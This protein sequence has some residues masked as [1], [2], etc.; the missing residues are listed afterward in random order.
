MNDRD[1]W[2]KIVIVGTLV[3]LAFASIH[4][5]DEKLKYGIDLYGGYSLLYEIDDTGVA[6][7][8]KRELSEKVM[9]VLR[10]RVDPKGVYNLVWRPVG[11]NRLEIQMPR[12][13][14]DVRKARL[15]YDH[16]Q[17][18]IQGT[19]LRRSDVLRALARSG[20]ERST[21]FDELIRGIEARKP[22]LNT[23]VKAYDDW[24]TMKAQYDERAKLAAKDN[25]SKDQIDDAM[26]QTGAERLKAI[27]ALIRGLPQRRVILDEAAKAW[28]AWNAA[29]PA[30]QAASPTTQAALEAAAK[31]TAYLEA[32][33]KVLALNADPAKFAEGAT[34]DKVVKLEEEF[35]AA[36]AALL[37]TNIDIG[38]LQVIL[39]TKPGTT[40]RKESLDSFNKDFS[41]VSRLVE[42]LLKANDELGKRRHGGEGRLEDPADLQR[43]LKGAGVLEFR[44]LAEGRQASPEKFEPYVEA[45]K[46]AGPRRSPGE[47]QYQWFEVEDP[48]DFLNIKD[49][50]KLATDFER[51][52][53]GMQ[54]IVERFGDKYYVLT[55]IGDAY[56]LT[57]RQ[58]E[59]DWSLKAA[60]FQ[61][62]Q[63]G[64]P[65]I[66]FE[67]DDVGGEH[68]AQLTRLNKGRQ[69]AIFLDDQAVSH[70]TIQSVIRNSGEITGTFTPQ[71]VQ[72]MVKK[73]DAGSLPRKLKDP[74]ISVKAIGPSLGE[75]NRTAGLRA[76]EY[77]SIAVVLFMCGFYL[78]AGSISI[79]ACAINILFT[80]SAMA[81]MGAT[82][83]LPGIA[84]LVLSIG[85]A[86][87]SNVLINERIREELARGTAM[88][89][90]IKHGYERAFS[91]ILDS[92]VTAIL[93]SLILYF[94]GSEE[95]KGFGLTLCIA[96][97]IN[98]FTAYFI[99][100]MFFDMMVAPSVPSEIIRKPIIASLVIIAIGAFLYGAGYY[101]NGPA[102]RDTSVL[103]AFGRAIMY[104]GPSTLGLL[105]LMY[106]GR[107]VHQM[108]QT[109][110]KPRLPMMHVIG[111][112]HID[113][114]GM[115]PFFFTASAILTIAGL[116]AF[117]SLG[118]KEIY[119][120]EFLGG[121][122][123]QI[124]LKQPGLL[125]QAGV[126]DRLKKS[127][128]KLDA[129]AA[130]SEKATLTSSAAATFNLS[131]PGVPAVR[132]E[133]V[134]KEVLGRKLS[135]MSPITYSDPASESM[136]IRTRTDANVTLDEMQRSLKEFAA[137]FR[138]AAEFIG[139]AQVQAIASAENPEE[140]DKSFEIITLETNKD[141]VVASIMENL[142][143]ELNIQRALSFNMMDNQALGAVS[144]F[145]LRS[146]NLKE[147][148]LPIPEAQANE[149]DLTGWKGSAA[150][151]LDK[152]DPPQKLD[153]LKDR[154]RAMR[155][156]PGFESHGWRESTVFGLQAVPG[157]DL[158][159][160]VMVVVADENY[161]IA[162]EQGGLS[163][164]WV[165]ELAEPEV[166][167][168]QSALQRQT[169]LSQI[170]QFDKQVSGEAQTNAFIA[171]G[172]SWLAII[173]YLWFRFGNI[174]W[175]LA[176]VVALIHDVIVAI[177][178]IGLA[179]YLADTAI[180]HALKLEK[181]RVDLGLVAAILTI[182]GYSVSDTIIIFDRIR[183]NR[184]RGGELTPEKVNTAISQTLARTF[185]TS[186]TTMST[187]V[188]MYWV[189]GP[190]IHGFNFAMM[191]GILTGTY[192]SFA[193]ASQLLVK[194][195]LIKAVATA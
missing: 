77:G 176:A 81:I 139:R 133:P 168:V 75:A 95:I 48:A 76:A 182:I 100:K 5:T 11:Y 167:L 63:F 23:T 150:M 64:R 49:R 130:A 89:M 16:L 65:A 166:Q 120:I 149:I 144:Y 22:L 121:T 151:I 135:E 164:T 138:R 82:L 26:K 55:H 31:E 107:M 30:A 157:S 124:D 165:S 178:C 173:I 45:L 186:F 94:L 86:V 61:R 70:A 110:D 28:D 83:T 53:P 126:Q 79:F 68:F 172:L 69:L 187:V 114:I 170:T 158:Y 122:S 152:V 184:G 148:G 54:V 43:L 131:T 51:M 140:K 181:F 57:H 102:A 137:R 52:K 40:A 146:D 163:P 183:E 36:L 20:P 92:H 98:L 47:E 80:L 160:R 99:T 34:V 147:L 90:A 66:G 2:W 50:R 159:S 39:D 12:P 189:G 190:G 27:D 60:R 175:G 154:L 67:L 91:A 101:W 97:V 84:G 156:Q 123:A 88:R 136:V 108:F 44:I 179:H 38:R 93:T 118:S 10:E 73:L 142:E 21:A 24:M 116:A 35:D 134:V 8:A 125:T 15:D 6:N 191:I 46:K 174:R 169:T 161:P 56:A 18:Q 113:W 195:R 29:K 7:D 33:R 37:A 143:H 85:M 87:D 109:G 194:R 105:I 115:K 188:I 162:D 180:G 153:V 129:F 112:P 74:P 1:M 4:P 111:V 155:L 128:E 62:D 78:Y 13:S 96:V 132:M 193:I 127:A 119:D 192:S 32:V 145:P 19:V 141:L 25:I 185:L 41:G 59:R 177:G 58:G 17:Q 103:I 104:I 3:A 71:E 72:D 117:F 9:S 106:L 42:D 14:E 171:M